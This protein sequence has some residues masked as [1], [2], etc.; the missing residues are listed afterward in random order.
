[1]TRTEGLDL[2]DEPDGRLWHM[3]ATYQAE[4][5]WAPPYVV[6]ELRAIRT[7]IIDTTAAATRAD[8]EATAARDRGDNEAAGR[9]ETIAVSARALGDFYRQRE[10]IDAGLVEDYQAWS[11]VTEGSRRVTVLAD[12]ELRRRHRDLAIE[13]LQSAEPLAS[14]PEAPTPPA[15]PAEIQ[16]LAEQAM[17]QREAFREQL[18]PR[19][20]VR[21]LRRRHGGCL[22]RPHGR[23]ASPDSPARRRTSHR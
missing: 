16:A 11:R 19:Q 4:T 18:E 8:A 9:H 12:A 23:H 1:M 10:D 20:G 22:D 7:A 6:E 15:D 3:R 14:P 2:R 5:A 21:P 13:P 17:R